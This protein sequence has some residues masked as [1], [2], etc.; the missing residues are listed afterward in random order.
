MFPALYG[1]STLVMQQLSAA[2]TVLGFSIQ[3]PLGLGKD[4]RTWTCHRE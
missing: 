3:G 1:L 4:D 2:S